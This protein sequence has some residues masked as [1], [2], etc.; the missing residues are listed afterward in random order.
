MARHSP[1]TRIRILSRNQMEEAAY[2]HWLERGCPWGDPLTDWLAVET[3]EKAGPSRRGGWVHWFRT[4]R[5]GES[6]KPGGLEHA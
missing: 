1:Q 3:E 4:N 2:Y 5:K 6:F